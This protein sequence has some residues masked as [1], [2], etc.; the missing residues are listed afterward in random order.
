MRDVA[1]LRGTFKLSTC[2]IGSTANLVGYSKGYFTQNIHSG[3]TSPSYM[4]ARF[5]D[6]LSVMLLTPEVWWFPACFYCAAVLQSH[7]E[8]RSAGLR[9]GIELVKEL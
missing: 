7:L 6:E 8:A 5:W 1:L 3:A 2:G 9:R 4:V